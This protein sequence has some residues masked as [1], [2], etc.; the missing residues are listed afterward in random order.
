MDKVESNGTFGFLMKMAAVKISLALSTLIR[1]HIVFRA[2]CSVNSC[3]V[4]ILFHVS[5]FRFPVFPAG[6]L[7]PPAYKSDY[8]QSINF[9]G[10]GFVVG[11]ELTHGF[12]NSGK[13][14]I[15]KSSS[16]RR[17]RG[18]CSLNV[19]AGKGRNE[20]QLICLTF[21]LGDQYLRLGCINYISVPVHSSDQYY[22]KVGSISFAREFFER[23]RFQ[24]RLSLLRFSDNAEDGRLSDKGFMLNFVIFI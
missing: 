4:S 1:D 15:G 11:H 2:Q 22:G 12:D 7:Q 5:L 17:S 21:Y 14:R 18:R 19:I 9:G 23:Q 6:V 13:I 16:A 8:P 3:R 24:V 20:F 10:I